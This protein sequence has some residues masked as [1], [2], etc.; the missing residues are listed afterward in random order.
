MKK[1]VALVLLLTT[2][3]TFFAFNV[4]AAD[5]QTVGIQTGTY[6]NSSNQIVIS[7]KI[8]QLYSHIDSQPIYDGAATLIP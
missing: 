5:Y 1:V 8:V 6:N 7:T 4:S 3:M 2:A